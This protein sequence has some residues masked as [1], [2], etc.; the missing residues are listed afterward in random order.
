MDKQHLYAVL[1][2]CLPDL[3][4][5]QASKCR[6]L[7]R[8]RQVLLFEED[9]DGRVQDNEGLRTKGRESDEAY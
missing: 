3:M 1:V 8:I 5:A 9:D 7:F 4:R 2:G 6:L